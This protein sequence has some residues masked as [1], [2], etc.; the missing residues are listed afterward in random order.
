MTKQSS[1]RP[2]SQRPASSDNRRTPP[3]TETEAELMARL[4]SYSGGGTQPM[5]DAQYREISERI[6][7]LQLGMAS[8]ELDQREVM[9]QWE[10]YQQRF[11]RGRRAGCLG[12][13]IRL[14]GCLAISIV[15]MLLSGGFVAILLAALS[16]LV[17]S[18]GGD[19]S[20]IGRLPELL[21]P[22][23]TSPDGLIPVPGAPNTTVLLGG[24]GA[25][26]ALAVIATVLVR[27]TL[28]SVFGLLALVVMIGLAIGGVILLAQNGT[29]DQLINQL[30]G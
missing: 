19:L 24:G 21:K 25:L 18:R 16:A 4:I 12:R 17:L 9:R 27:S 30:P 23:T 26:L 22:L 15:W 8:Q 29:L 2:Q 28:R 3:Q 5:T 10:T 1:Q 13:I 14:P 20:F 11:R 7:Q 6:A